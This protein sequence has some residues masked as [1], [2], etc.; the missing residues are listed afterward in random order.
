M[1]ARIA[2][3]YTRALKNLSASARSR[4]DNIIDADPRMAQYL[5]EY[6]MEN[7]ATSPYPIA[8]IP[9]EDYLRLARRAEPHLTDEQ[10]RLGI[11]SRM[12]HQQPQ[13][14]GPWDLSGDPDSTPDFLRKYMRD[15]PAASSYDIYRDKGIG[16][17]RDLDLHPGVDTFGDADD[18]NIDLGGLST[19]KYT[20]RGQKGI[21]ITDHEG[22]GRNAFASDV[23]TSLPSHMIERT[24]AIPNDPYIPLGDIDEIM[25]RLG[26]SRREI[27]RGVDARD[28][29][30]PV[31]LS[32]ELPKSL[33][34]ARNFLQQI[35]GAVPE[36]YIK[37]GLNRRGEFDVP[38]FQ[39]AP[40]LAIPWKY[41]VFAEGGEVEKPGMLQ[42]A[43][44]WIDNL[45]DDA[46][47]YWSNRIEEGRGTDDRAKAENAFMAR[48]FLSP[49]TFYNASTDEL[50]TSPFGLG[51]DVA[52]IGGM[53][54]S[55]LREGLARMP[56]LPMGHIGVGIEAL[57]RSAELADK[58]LG[59][60]NDAFARKAEL[61]DE[62]YGD[63]IPETFGER[64]SS[65]IAENVPYMMAGAG[66]I[67][68]T[69]LLKLAAKLGRLP[70]KAALATG[71]L[72][73]ELGLVAGMSGIEGTLGGPE[74]HDSFNRDVAEYPE[75]HLMSNPRAFNTAIQG[76][77]PVARELARIQRGIRNAR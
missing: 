72:G 17:P 77:D 34:E 41:P 60:A 28:H 35:K 36:D 53:I 19:L 51:Q 43:S 10:S 50:Q 75:E 14:L 9:P 56:R 31:E 2:R 42:R 8:V 49:V 52:G 65:G 76:N 70:T 61:M 48:G 69:A 38:G 63:V 21:S 13:A 74:D 25:E 20:P 68:T 18:Y 54:N 1:P 40:P 64:M 30:E 16:L 39:R 66:I 73:S 23:G 7:A 67:P 26:R 58:W 55:G 59:P 5:N 47:T 27:S 46:G 71:L 29:G 12:Q 62:R 11:L 4:L 22:R 45:G 33:D 15:H 57:R 6:G 24:A 32:P 44:E 37:F 3:A